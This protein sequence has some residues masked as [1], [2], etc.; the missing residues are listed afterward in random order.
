[1]RTL[2]RPMFRMGGS[3][4][5]GITSGLEKPKR[6]LVDEPGS[7]SQNFNDIRLKDLGDKSIGDLRKISQSFRPKETYRDRDDFL[8]NLGLDLV[9]RPPS[10]NIVSTIGAAAKQPFQQLQASKAQKR[11]TSTAEEADLF[12]T[13]V[14]AQAKV[15]GSEGGSKIFSKEQAANAVARLMGEWQDLRDNRGEMSEEEFEDQKAIIFGQIQQYQKEN[16]AIASLFKDKDFNTSVK[17]K[18]KRQLQSSQKIIKV[19]NPEGEGTIELTEA[20]Y[21]NDDRNAMELQ[22]EIGKRFLEYYNNMTMYGVG[23][24]REGGKEGGRMGYQ[25]GMSVMPAAGDMGQETGDMG[26]ETMPEE[27]QQNLTFEE[28]RNRLP[29]EV[30]DDIINLILSSAE[31]MEDFATIQTEQD[32]SNFNKKYGVNLVLPSEG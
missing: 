19:P 20:Q 30:T 1:M 26:Q 18:I 27:L 28:L 29:Q 6:G 21:Y 4:N 14:G 24:V 12:K 32:I 16:P 3:A 13:L 2:R 15:L 5:Q 17:S 8:I 7:Y 9:S 22:Q 31:A 10:S 25:Q 23:A 11:M